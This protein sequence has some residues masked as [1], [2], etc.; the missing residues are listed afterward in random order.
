MLKQCIYLYRG[1]TRNISDDMWKF[2]R[3]FD[4]QP[5]WRKINTH[6]PTE[7]PPYR[8]NSN[9]FPE[10][11][12]TK[13]LIGYST[14]FAPAHD[15]SIHYQSPLMLSSPQTIASPQRKTSTIQRN[16]ASKKK[17]HHYPPPPAYPPPL[18]APPPPPHSQK[19]SKS[20]SATPPRPL[21]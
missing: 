12:L 10:K 2:W 19:T 11:S 16:A 21:D 5:R 17:T 4:K 3:M 1:Q 8:L 20:F 9:L 14:P 6:L 18:A 7:N 15:H 13:N